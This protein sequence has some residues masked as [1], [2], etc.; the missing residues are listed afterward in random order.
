MHRM[1]CA[2]IWGGIK[3]EDQDVCSGGLT[4]SLFCDACDGGKG[5]DIY[6]L[7]V[8]GHDSLTRIAVA[9]VVGHGKVVSDISTWLYEA[10]KRRMNDP[11]GHDILSELNQLAV[12]RGY[13]AM[14]T[15]AVVAYYT[16]DDNGYFAYAGHLPALLRR[17]GR[18]GYAE[19]LNVQQSGGHAN[20]PLGI[21]T[22]VR[23]DQWCVQMHPGDRLFLYTDGVVEAPDADGVLFGQQRLIETLDAS[24]GDSLATA[25]HAVLDA[26]RG[27]TGGSMSHDDVTLMAIEVN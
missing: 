4:A 22:Q 19:V 6:Y 24:D 5:G 12:T 11:A 1:T 8:C 21:M 23:Y 18:P 25:K 26:V 2:E 14:T 15:A 3:D 10:L 16:A 27:H 20:L 7:S 9:D 17:R 13:N